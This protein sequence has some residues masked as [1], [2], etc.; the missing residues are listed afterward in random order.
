MWPTL[1]LTTHR[2]LSHVSSLWEEWKWKSWII[3]KP[4][5][6]ESGGTIYAFEEGQQSLLIH[7]MKS[8]PASLRI[9]YSQ[10]N[11]IAKD[12]SGWGPLKKAAV[13]I[14]NQKVRHNSEALARGE[15]PGREPSRAKQNADAGGWGFRTTTYMELTPPPALDGSKIAAEKKAAGDEYNHP[16]LESELARFF[17][18]PQ[19]YGSLS[20]LWAKTA[21]CRK[22]EDSSLLRMVVE[23]R[24]LACL[25][26]RLHQV[27][28]WDNSDPGYVMP[29]G[30]LFVTPRHHPFQTS[31]HSDNALNL[32]SLA[33]LAYADFEWNSKESL[34]GSIYDF[35]HKL[36]Y[37]WQKNAADAP[38]PVRGLQADTVNSALF[39]E[40]RPFLEGYP[41]ADLKFFYNQKVDAQGFAASDK[42]TVVIGLRGTSDINDWM[43]NANFS[44][45]P[46]TEVLP[47]PARVHAGF[48]DA[49]EVLSADIER[50]CDEHNAAAKTI[51]VCGH[52]LGGAM[53]TLIALALHNIYNKRIILYTFGCP[54]VG[55]MDF[56]RVML[57]RDIVHYRFVNHNDP[58]TRVPENTPEITAVKAMLESSLPGKLLLLRGD[59]TPFVYLHHGNFCHIEEYAGYEWVH[60]R[61]A[62]FDIQT[63]FKGGLLKTPDS[64]LSGEWE[65]Y[66]LA[67]HVTDHLIGRYVDNLV[68]AYANRNSVVYAEQWK[69]LEEE[70]KR[71]RIT[72]M[73]FRW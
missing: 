47:P 33:A 30:A 66:N 23:L 45:T 57:G 65:K 53:A 46:Y 44:L 24:G 20:L 14:G 60:V 68:S 70:S 67:G 40:E 13:E 73:D 42:D 37:S 64:S 1:F 48:R 2:N 5:P 10:K 63:K 15:T 12:P 7:K 16:K 35:F 18:A 54:R 41:L 31:T 19:R 21:Q 62:K 38:Q 55:N 29:S 50:Y 4:I 27:P 71:A 34:N 61:L 22:C 49:A 69:S 43:T 32:A 72:L 8:P 25:K 26:P 52:S 36:A 28:D 17:S 59:F 3:G 56:V 11:D 9:Y 39:L 58:V 51:Y 6:S